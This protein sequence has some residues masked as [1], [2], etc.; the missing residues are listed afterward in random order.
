MYKFDGHW[1]T[2]KDDP[3]IPDLGS[4]VCTDANN[5]Q[6]NYCGLL[7]DKAKL[8]TYD[9]LMSGST[10]SLLSTS[11]LTVLMYERTNKTWYEI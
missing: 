1:Y 11:G 5:G 8:P 3:N 10:A 7:S 2:S 4:L 9:D 6:R